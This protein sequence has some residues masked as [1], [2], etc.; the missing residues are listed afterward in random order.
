MY[1]SG[2]NW[3]ATLLLSASVLSF[4][5]VNLNQQIASATSSGQIKSVSYDKI[6]NKHSVSYSAYVNENNRNGGLH[7]APATGA[8]SMTSTGLAKSLNGHLVT[9]SEIDTTKRA[10][11]GNTYQYAKINFYGNTYWVDVRALDN[12]T[13]SGAIMVNFEDEHGNQL[14]SSIEYTGKIGSTYQPE[15]KAITGYSVDLAKTGSTNLTYSSTTQ[16]IT[17]IYE[18]STATTTD[19]LSGQG[20][21][22]SNDSWTVGTDVQPG[23]YKITPIGLGTD[24]NI[25]LNVEGSDSSDL[26]LANDIS[27]AWFGNNSSA[28]EI[29][30]YQAYLTAGQ[31]IEMQDNNDAITDQGLHLEALLTRP[32]TSLIDPESPIPSSFQDLGAGI[33][34]VGVDIRPGDYQVADIVGQGYLYTDDG[35]VGLNL[36]TGHGDISTGTI[37]LTTGEF[38]TSTVDGISLEP[39]N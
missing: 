30:S 20:Q 4:Y 34:E 1:K 26:P 11:N 38:L 36:G 32:A 16:T 3:V 22:T 33:Y 13:Y 28:G 10:S 39:E 21:G 17:Y 18:K 25:V 14:A 6:S 23:W 7:L 2:K 19:L 27:G 9:V 15:P 5:S 24:D 37:T 12:S 35:T 31:V 29:S 8:A